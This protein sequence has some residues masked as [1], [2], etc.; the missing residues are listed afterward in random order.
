MAYSSHGDG[1]LAITHI[2]GARCRC[3]W[4]GD[5]IM[6]SCR[7]RVGAENLSRCYEDMKVRVCYLVFCVQYYFYFILQYERLTG[8]TAMP[9]MC[10][11]WVSPFLLRAGCVDGPWIYG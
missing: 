4:M 3:C 8:S 6:D 9:L 10:F 11:S 2:I 1:Q 7:L 5:P